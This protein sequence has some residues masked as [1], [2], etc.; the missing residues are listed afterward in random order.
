MPVLLLLA[1]FLPPAA[2]GERPEEG[3][4]ALL[5]AQAQ[6][7]RGDFD[8]AIM[9]L[10]AG[11]AARPGD[12]R[13]ERSLARTLERYVDAGGLWL[14]MSDARAAWDRALALEPGELDTQCGAIA[15]RLR[16]GEYEEAL[17]L[18]ERA[19]GAAWLSGG[20][21]PP[22]L[23]ELACRARLGTLPARDSA[24]PEARAAA[25]GRA[26][27]AL[28]HA[29]ALAGDSSALVRLAAGLLEAEGLSPRAAEELALAIERAQAAGGEAVADLHRAL[30]DLHVR[31]G[32]EERLSERYAQWSGAGTNATLAWFTGYVWRLDGDLAQ[33]ERRFAAALEAYER[34]GRWMGV[35]A[36]LQPSFEGTAETIRFQAQVSS[37]WCEIES[38]ALEAAGERLLQLLRRD[39]ARRDE[40]DGLGRSLMHALAALGERRVERSDFARAAAEA[41]AIL[42]LLPED[43]AAR[44]S[45][46]NNLGF[47]AR[48]HATQLA[49]GLLPEEGADEARSRAVFRESWQAYRRAVELMGEDVRVLNDAALVQVHHLRDN[50]AEAEA[51]LERAIRLGESQLAALGSQPDERARFPLAQALGDALL[52]LGYLAYHVYRQ[53]GRA[54]EAFERALATDSGARPEIETY[55]AAIDGRRG[56]VSEPDRGTLVAAPR[57]AAP[58]RAWPAWESSLGEA[59]ERARAEGRFLLV[60]QRGH[61]LG[62]AV[63]ELDARVTSPEFVRATQG[64]VLLLSD[65]ERAT[66]VDRRRDGRRVSCPRFGTVTCGEHVRVHA[67]AS[68]WLEE[69]LG[70]PPGESEE[71]LWLFAPGA[72]RPELLRD[73]TRLAELPSP[74]VELAGEPFEALEA[75][76]GGEDGGGEAR[77]LVGTRS[78]SARL[79]AER[80]LWDGFR[81]SPARAFLL[82]ALAES[83]SPDAREL[84]AAS[85]RQCVDGELQRAALEVWPAGAELE[86]VVH[87]WRWSPSSEARAVAEKVLSRER[88]GDPV[89]AA[90]EV[91]AR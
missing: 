85:A 86:P 17:A 47:L 44:G 6:L 77:L 70:A 28:R 61:G 26:W 71:G 12:A 48:E 88:P 66:F 36:T 87:A 24:A 40:P 64:V 7:A 39:A 69:C 58:E 15:V 10:E 59:R 76:L 83:P 74:T 18:S 84:L 79:V 75:S 5:E 63:E 43:A 30:I 9:V 11:L 65:A 54:R 82:A 29:R 27:A 45:W 35:A 25:L 90:R 42:A 33:R 4:D 68:A 41:R 57:R 3:S 49:A 72:D 13:L 73:L 81:S 21:G 89:W 22:A 32:I 46:W 80:I 78:L 20:S 50:L 67:E 60:Y 91:L 16:L 51:L 14:A 34:A 8:R 2:Q 23:L 19:L 38:G 56:P 55:L 52:N 31:E 53:P 37:A 62:L 1:L